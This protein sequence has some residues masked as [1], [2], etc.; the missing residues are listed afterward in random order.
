MTVLLEA[1]NLVKRF[2]GVAA[3]DGVSLQVRQGEIRGLIGPNGSG[4]TTLV[5]LLAGFYPPDQGTIRLRGETIE[6]LRPDQRLARGLMRTFQIPK[7][8]GDMTVLDNLLVPALS[9]SQSGRRSMPEI[10]ALAEQSLAFCNLTHLR[11]QL[12][13]E[14][15]GGQKML[16][17]IMRG[18]MVE[19]LHLYIMDEP[20]TGINPALKDII[21]EAIL[22]MNAER[23]VTFLIISH[24]MPTIR[25][26]C[27]TISVM[28]EG[29]LIAEGSLPQVANNP[30]VIE[31]YL[32]GSDV[33]AHD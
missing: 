4:K 33:L 28:H 23:G 2:G 21:M 7:L 26:L 27:Q 32:G 11:H 9:D 29:R 30:L 6:A 10:L 15:S 16:L 3:V 1:E 22:T 31:A 24:E 13:K 17:Q 25:K 14:I 18:F 12:A 19:E 8:F 20:F 5:N